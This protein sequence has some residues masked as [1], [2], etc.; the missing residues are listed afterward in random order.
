MKKTI[1]I[2]END[3]EKMGQPPEQDSCKEK[4][5][6]ANNK[7]NQSKDKTKKKFQKPNDN[8]NNINLYYN[9]FDI[10]YLFI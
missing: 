8:V 6:M 4:N 1:F 3:E 10:C 5:K 2:N 9:L 7:T